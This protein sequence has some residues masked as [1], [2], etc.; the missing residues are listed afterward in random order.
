MVAIELVVFRKV[1]MKVFN[2]NAPQKMVIAAGERFFIPIYG[3]T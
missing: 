3:Y 2:T 1:K